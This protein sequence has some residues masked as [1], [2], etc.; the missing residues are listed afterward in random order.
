MKAGAPPASTARRSAAE[1][2]RRLHAVIEYIDRHLEGNLELARLADVA[3]FS[4]FH[5]HRLFGALTGEA[6]GDYVRRRRL[7][8]A[9]LRLRS[10]SR[11]PVLEIALGVGFG[12][13]EAFTRAFRARFD[14]SPSE[15]RKSKYDQ[16][17]RKAGQ[18]PRLARRKNGRSQR[19]E[20]AMKVKLVDRQPVSVVYLRH[21]G[22]YGATISR[23]WMKEVAPWMEANNF[24][25]RERFG[26]SLDDPSITKPEM[27]RYDAC[28]ESPVGEMVAGD[29]QRKVIPGGKYATLA[30]EGTA[31][32]IGAA[33]DMLLRDWLPK[34][35]LQLDARPFF[36]HYPVDGR[37]DSKTGAFSC[38]IC[39]PVAPL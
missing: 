18:A 19:K 3:H 1:Y 38:N 13:A 8:T 9:A 32:D 36:E 21:T 39:V 10:Q 2:A 15:W 7:E 16:M 25:G 33:W 34:S 5:F 27:C 4:A 20:P 30:Y 28:V 29:P 11:V 23:F 6:L 12:S 24:F 14:C 35:G 26:I 37:Y 31:A 22:P 17:A